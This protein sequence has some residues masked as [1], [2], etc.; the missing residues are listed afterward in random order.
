MPG[1]VTSIFLDTNTIIGWLGSESEGP[2]TAI[3]GILH[4]IHKREIRAVVSQ[5]TRLEILE[6]KH[7]GT[8]FRAWKNLQGRPNVEVMGITK[9]VIDTAYEIRNYYQDARELDPSRKKPPTQP[10]CILIATGIIAGVDYFVSYDG[11]KKDPKHLSP[12]ELDPLVAGQWALNI[13]R[14][15]ALNLSGLSV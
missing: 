12:H 5:L 8:M 10:D 15:E 14:P 13:T 4:A 6:C 9:K 2:I 3:S 7:S 1:K 11:G